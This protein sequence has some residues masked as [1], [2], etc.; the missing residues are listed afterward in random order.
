MLN[1]IKQQMVRHEKESYIANHVVK[2]LLCEKCSQQ[3]YRDTLKI[4]K[5]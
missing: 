1:S 2:R 3:E 5:E 4:V